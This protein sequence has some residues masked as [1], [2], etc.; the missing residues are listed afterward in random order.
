MSATNRIFESI[1]N[2]VGSNRVF[3]EPVTSD[4]VTVIPAYRVTGGGG[5]G[6]GPESPEDT[7]GKTEPDT[8]GGGGFGVVARPVGAFVISGD[9]VRW[10]PTIDVT[11]IVLGGQLVGIAYFLSTWLIARTNARA[12]IK[13]A[14][15]G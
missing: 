9:R 14:R 4:G 3:G 13:I 12:A 5:G 15:L 6:E 7:E 11:R 8:G 10:K 1:G 2:A